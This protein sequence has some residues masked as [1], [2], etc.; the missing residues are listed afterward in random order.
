MLLRLLSNGNALL[1]EK[2]VSGAKT[3]ASGE[4]PENVI[5]MYINATLEGT[6]DTLRKILLEM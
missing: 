2:Q 4:G 6:R 5:N 1:D 3:E